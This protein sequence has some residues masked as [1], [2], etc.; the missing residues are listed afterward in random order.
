MP[1]TIGT[2]TGVLLINLGTPDAPESP[3]V[4]RYLREFLSD[5]RVLDMSAAG[6]W[7]LLNFVILPR[8]PAA[9]AAAYRKIWTD[10]GSPLLVHGRALASSVQAELGPSFEVALAMR[11]GSPS[12]ASAMQDLARRGAD[13]LVVFALYPHYSS[14]STGSTLERVYA[15]A[16][17]EWNTP[18][19][20]AVPPFYDHPAFISAF[21]AVG[22][23][24]LGE[25]RP[26]H[27]VFSY[28]GLPERHIKKSDATGR[29]CL[30][31]PDCC[32]RIVEANRNCYRAQCFETTRLLAAA[33]GI[34]PARATVAFQSRL[35]RT[36]WILP[37]T[38]VVLPE[39]A[40]KGVRRVAVFCPAFIADCL[41]T[42][43]EIGIRARE[44]FVE[45]GGE[46]LRLVPS[47]NSHPLW[48]KA[49]TQLVRTAC[50][51]PGREK[52]PPS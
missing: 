45:A 14:A 19:V 35:G 5:P 10:A 37:Y 3:E 8:R 51:A 36:P 43:E 1:G 47:L 52:R 32:A 15:L 33:L 27:V 23:P 42:L 13:D 46:E 6:R 26:D 34:E 12:I 31:S 16:A 29:H 4:R 11:Y 20:T 17:R 48:V 22:R 50:P 39:L 44:T 38:D 30:A 49:V 18:F 41:E 7:L 9:S 25:L 40:A 28:H 2:R 24:V 21:A